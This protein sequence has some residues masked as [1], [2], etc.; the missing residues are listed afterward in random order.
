MWD[1]IH[2]TA[3][4]KAGEAYNLRFLPREVGFRM[5][6][7]IITNKTITPTGPVKDVNDM[8]GTPRAASG[9]I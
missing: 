1:E 4:L 7:V 5:D 9:P 8:G 6:Q 3:A 2:T